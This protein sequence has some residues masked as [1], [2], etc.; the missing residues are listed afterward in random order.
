MSVGCD[1]R[2][3]TEPN[4]P[5]D[6]NAVAVFD[7]GRRVAYIRRESAFHIGKIISAVPSG[8]FSI[9]PE[10]EPH[11]TNRGPVQFCSLIVKIDKINE[12]QL[13]ASLSGTGLYQVS[14]AMTYAKLQWYDALKS[15][16]H[17]FGVG[18]ICFWFSFLFI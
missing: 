16:G 9:R 4:N 7:G 10:K 5:F 1:Y 17:M 18:I 11:Y 8:S 12:E 2:C 14:S 13:F 3:N 6:K 15:D